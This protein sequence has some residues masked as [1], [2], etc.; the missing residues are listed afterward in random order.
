MRRGLETG[1]RI[2]WLLIERNHKPKLLT[3]HIRK[4]IMEEAGTDERTIE[5]YFKVLQEMGW[6]ERKSRYVYE[7]AERG[8]YSGIL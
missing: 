7:I 4:A 5:K 8:Q 2:M 6:L 3:R 1:K